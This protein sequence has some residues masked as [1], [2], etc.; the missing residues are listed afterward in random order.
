MKLKKCHKYVLDKY[1][2]S[3]AD[4][5]RREGD[6]VERADGDCTDVTIAPLAENT[7]SPATVACCKLSDTELKTEVSAR[8]YLELFS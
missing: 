4:F 1:P 6:W 8:L 7:T 5:F 3:C 2:A